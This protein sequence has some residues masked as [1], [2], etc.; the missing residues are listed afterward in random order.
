MKRIVINEVDPDAFKGMFVLE[1]YIKNSGFSSKLKNIMKIRSS[2]L[3]G[4]YP[5]SVS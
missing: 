1:S 5:G 2:Q 4:A 3:N